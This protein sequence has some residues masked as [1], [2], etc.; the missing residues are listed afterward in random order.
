[1]LYANVTEV[2]DNSPSIFYLFVIYT[3]YLIGEE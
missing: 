2:S 3:P 1:M